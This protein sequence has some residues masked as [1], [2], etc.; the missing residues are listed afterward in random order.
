[1]VDLGEGAPLLRGHCCVLPPPPRCVLSPI[2]GLPN[3]QLSAGLEGVAGPGGGGGGGGANMGA[4]GGM[5]GGTGMKLGG[6]CA[7]GGG[8]TENI[9]KKPV[10]MTLKLILNQGIT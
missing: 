9:A 1:M 5:G 4:G 10:S 3:D 2:V 7:G 8:D 6:A